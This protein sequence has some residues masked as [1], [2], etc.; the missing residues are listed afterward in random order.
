MIHLT[1]TTVVQ[2]YHKHETSSYQFRDGHRYRCAG[3]TFRQHLIAH[4]ARFEYPRCFL[5]AGL[6]C[7]L[8]SL[9]LCRVS[10]GVT[11]E[12]PTTVYIL[13]YIM[14]CTHA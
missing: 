8:T 14:T 11:P 2:L 6:R 7:K 5:I 10:V 4:P 3:K 13:A 12:G 1:V 9:F